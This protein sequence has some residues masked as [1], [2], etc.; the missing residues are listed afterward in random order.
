M[1]IMVGTRVKVALGLALVLLLEKVNAELKSESK[2]TK[3][4]CGSDL[5]K[6]KSKIYVTNVTTF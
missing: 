6:K 1:E 5:K 2:A 4:S 3:K